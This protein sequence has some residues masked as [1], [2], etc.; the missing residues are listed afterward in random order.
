MHRFRFR[1]TLAA[2]ALLVATPLPAFELTGEPVQGGLMFGSAEPGSQVR[3]GDT[4]VP[5][6]ADGRF[7]IGFGRDDTG[8]V[9]LIVS[10]PAGEAE[11]R[12]LSI[13]PREFDIERVDGLPPSTVTPDPEALARIREEAAQVGQA[14][15]LRDGRSDWKEGFAWPAHGRLSGFYGSQR[16]LNGEPRNPHYGLDVAAPEGSPVTAPADGLVTLVHPDMYFSR[17]TIIIDHGAGLSSTFL[18]LSEVLVDTGQVVRQGALIGR[19]GATGRATGPHLDWRMN[20]L[21]RRVDP[22]TVVQGQPDGS[23]P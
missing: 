5:V 2:A 7:A 8:T 10:P 3:L 20:W 22:L 21:D 13:T 4:E 11:I 6:A 23:A 15:A 18:H 9:T 19:V 14:R 12:E 16:I 17:G 1:S